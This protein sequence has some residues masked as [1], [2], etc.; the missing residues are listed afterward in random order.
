MH[1]GGRHRQVD[2]E[3][4]RDGKSTPTGRDG[5]FYG[6]RSPYRPWP[7][8][9]WMRSIIALVSITLEKSFMVEAEHLR[10]TRGGGAAAG[11]MVGRARGVKASITATNLLDSTSRTL[12]PFW[13][14]V[15]VTS[16]KSCKSTCFF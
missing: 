16:I 10:N 8:T 12:T 4:C 11:F 1:H 2:R 9:S 7:C 13:K 15:V 14:K 5:P 6:S 3:A